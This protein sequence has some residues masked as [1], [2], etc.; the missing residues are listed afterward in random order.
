[1]NLSLRPFFIL[2]AMSAWLYLVWNGLVARPH[3]GRNYLKDRMT[4]T[5]A[6]IEYLDT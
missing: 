6:K 2:V 4:F 5:S 1:M 3:K